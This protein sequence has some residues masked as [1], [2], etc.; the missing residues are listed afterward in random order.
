[1]ITDCGIHPSF[2]PNCHRRIVY[3]KLDL[4]IVYPLPYQR[5]VW[6]FKRANI[7]SIRKAIKMIDGH[8]MLLKKNV[9]EQVS[10]F[11]TTLMNI[12]P[13]CIASKYI[14]VDDKPPWMAGAIK[15]KFYLKKSLSRPKNFIGLQNWAIEILELISIRK[16][17]YY[18]H[19]SKKLNDPN[20][21]AKSYWSILKSFY[22]GN[23]VPLTPPLLVNNKTVS[24]F[25][26]KANLFNDFFFLLSV[27]G[28][29][30]VVCYSTEIFL[31]LIKDYLHLIS[32]KMIFLK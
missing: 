5:H 26:E 27:H 1:M 31:K 28:S 13:N 15:N 11:N 21:S 22:K 4:K 12:F 19:L 7:D 2:H 16:E 23:M 29:V 8:F 10:S 32:R 17:E 20:A 24:D 9:H 30:I 18:N 6:N 25:I 14:T 3:C